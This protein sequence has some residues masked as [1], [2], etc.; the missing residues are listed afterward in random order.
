MHVL[1][2]RRDEHI[3]KKKKRK[4]KRRDVMNIY[5]C[6]MKLEIEMVDV[7]CISLSRM[8]R[9]NL[10]VYYTKSI[11]I[12]IDEFGSGSGSGVVVDCISIVLNSKA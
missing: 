10:I 6:V 3:I 4:K 9:I 5:L 11:R 2:L 1:H 7:A 12:D 8:S